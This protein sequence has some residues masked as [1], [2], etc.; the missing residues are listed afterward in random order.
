MICTEGMAPEDTAIQGAGILTLS[1]GATELMI[2]ALLCP[3]ASH[4]NLHQAVSGTELR[5]EDE[6]AWLVRPSGED[7]HKTSLVNYVSA[8]RYRTSLH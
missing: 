5:A 6:A 8:T 3:G 2:E 4:P 7:V 1:R